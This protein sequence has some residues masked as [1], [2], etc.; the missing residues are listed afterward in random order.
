MQT[1]HQPPKGAPDDRT[2]DHALDIIG[3]AE[4]SLQEPVE[5]TDGKID[6]GPAK[7]QAA[8]AP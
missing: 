5:K 1:E 8:I 2:Q 4:K 6:N 3:A 7:N